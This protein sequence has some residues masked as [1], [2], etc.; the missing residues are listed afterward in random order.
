MRERAHVMYRARE[1]MMRDIDELGWL[2]SHENGK[3]FAEAKAEVEKG[4]ECVEYG[5]SLPN[6]A[7]G[8]ELEV[9]RGVTCGLT[10][11]PLGVVAGV[12][13]FNF[14]LWCP[15]WLPHR[16]WEERVHPQA[17]SGALRCAWPS[18]SPKRLPRESSR[19][20]REA[21]RR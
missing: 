1:I 6:L 20:S 3:L 10:Y 16:W 14:P 4:I 15:S 5:C 11:E 13:P 12:V 8:S 9:S 2:V 17:S 21:G 19:S 18:C 7:T